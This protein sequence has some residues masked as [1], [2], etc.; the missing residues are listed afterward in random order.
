M[1]SMSPA[2]ASV[3]FSDLPRRPAVT[4]QFVQTYRDRL[5][6]VHRDVLFPGGNADQPVAIAE[7]L[8][9]EPV[10]LR[11][12][13]EGHRAGS[14][15]FADQAAAV[16]QASQRDDALP[17]AALRSFPPPACSRPRRRQ[18]SSYSSALASSSA[19]PTA[20]RA[21]RNAFSYGFTT[22]SREKPKLLMARAAAPMLRGL[23]D[24]TSTTRRRSSLRGAGKTAYSKSYERER[25]RSCRVTDRPRRG[26]CPQPAQSS[27][28]ST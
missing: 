1:R 7:V 11:T 4:N 17:D 19:A 22:R 6:Q 5:A 24:D 3:C 28:C 16:F 21:V 8:L 20:D 14:H 10:S 2:V 18:R 13:Q 25:P 26:G 27:A 9:R 23:R 12:K 15:V